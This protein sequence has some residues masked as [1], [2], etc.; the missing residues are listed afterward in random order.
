ML[1]NDLIV[2]F[3]FLLRQKG[4]TVIN[5]AGLAI[6]TCCF[7]LIALLV[8]DEFAYDRFHEHADRIYR[9]TLDAKIGDKE[10]LTA[11]SSAGLAPTLISQVPGVEAAGKFR[12]VG[13]HA[14]RYGDRTFNEYKLYLCDSTLFD[15]FSFSVLERNR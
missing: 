7:L 3:R 1:K 12:V 8:W 2:A 14:I 9:L 13:D 11:R 15:V 5:V 4:S 6:G 10:F